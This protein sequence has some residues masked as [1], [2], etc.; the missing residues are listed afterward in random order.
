MIAPS[1][2]LMQ[3]HGKTEKA[4]KKT[5][6]QKNHETLE[7]TRLSTSSDNFA[8]PEVVGIYIWGYIYIY[9]YIWRIEFRAKNQ[10]FL[11]D[12]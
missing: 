6:E 1:D 9:M 11:E 8:Q 4:K 5:K 3:G 7:K 2:Q 12:F 10:R